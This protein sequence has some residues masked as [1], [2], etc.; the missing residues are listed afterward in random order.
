MNKYER[1]RLLRAI[2]LLARSCNNTNLIN[3]WLTVGIADGDAESDEELEY[4]AEDDHRFAEIMAAFLET[5]TFA[6]NSGGLYCDGVS[7]ERNISIE[8]DVEPV[9]PEEMKDAIDFISR[10][11]NKVT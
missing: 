5:M 8:L 11:F 4:Y 9:S 1:I 3:S 7:T 2:D 6:Y 10:R